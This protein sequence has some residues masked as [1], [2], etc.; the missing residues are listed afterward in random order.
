MIPLLECGWLKAPQKVFGS[1]WSFQLVFYVQTSLL[2]GGKNKKASFK[3]LVDCTCGPV[4]PILKEFLINL[5]Q[6]SCT[7][8]FKDSAVISRLIR[9]TSRC[10]VAYFFFCLPFTLSSILCCNSMSLQNTGLK[11]KEIS[12]NGIK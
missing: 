3:F 6:K 5:R 10:I 8:N 1:L 12:N 4:S 7:R 2:L 11:A 9:S